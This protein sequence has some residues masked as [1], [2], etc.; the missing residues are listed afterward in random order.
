MV[1]ARV[2]GNDA[3]IAFGQTGCFLELN[4]M[5]PVTAAALLESIE[6]LAAAAANFSA[7]AIDGLTATDRGPAAR[8]AGPDARDGPGA[9]HR[10]RRGRR[11]WP[12]K[13]SRAGGRS[14]SWPWSAGWPPTSWTASSIRP[15]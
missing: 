11:S 15:R 14:A 1:V 4:V 3:T 5:L 9:G 8:R 10:L 13:R 2:V 7:R 12:R 6:L